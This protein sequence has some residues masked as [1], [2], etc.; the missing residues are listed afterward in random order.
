M[1]EDH[2]P[3]FDRASGIWQRGG[4]DIENLP[5][6]FGPRHQTADRPPPPETVKS[7]RRWLRWG[8]NNFAAL[9]LVTLIG[10]GLTLKGALH[11]L[12]PRLSQR[13]L[14]YVDEEKAWG[15]QV[16]GAFGVLLGLAAGW[17]SLGAPPLPG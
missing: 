1:A 12:W 8:F 7:R 5:D 4:A 2:G 15:F 9:L 11:F 10:C 13:T 6:I 16:A 3:D 14:A 17:V